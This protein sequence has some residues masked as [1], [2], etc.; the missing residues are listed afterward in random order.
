MNQSTPISSRP[1]DWFTPILVRATAAIAEEYFL[2]PGKWARKEKVYRER[3]YC[4]ELYHRMRLELGGDPTYYVNGEIDKSLHSYFERTR[5]RPVPDLLVHKPNCSDHDHAVIEVKSF[6]GARRT[7]DVCR[8]LE[9]LK[10]FKNVGYQR[11]IYLIYGSE[12]GAAAEEIA[13]RIGHT[14]ADLGLN[15]DEFELWLHPRFGQA[16]FRYRFSDNDRL[17]VCASGLRR[18]PSR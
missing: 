13:T 12:L 1:T 15:C 17:S 3:V 18:V 14:G 7:R 2:L 4:Y 5:K 6:C 9:K 11:A 10:D 8:D 16:A